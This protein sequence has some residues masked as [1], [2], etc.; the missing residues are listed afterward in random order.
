MHQIFTK[1]SAGL[2]HIIFLHGY[3]GTSMTAIKLFQHLHQHFQVHALDAFGI[4]F[5]SRGK[6]AEEFTYEQTRD[7]YV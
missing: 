6:Y 5:S 3:G 7:Y 2:P 1:G 4:G